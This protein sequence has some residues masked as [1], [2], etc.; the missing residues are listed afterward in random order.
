MKPSRQLINSTIARREKAEGQLF[1]R[2]S[3]TQSHC[4]MPLLFQREMVP[5][6]VDLAVV[7]AFGE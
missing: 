2:N 1:A 5:A 3:R 6:G 7:G 4:K